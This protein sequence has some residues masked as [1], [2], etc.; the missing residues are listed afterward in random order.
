[1]RSHANRLSE[2]GE[3]DGYTVL[4]GTNTNDIACYYVPQKIV[5]FKKYQTKNLVQASLIHSTH[6]DFMSSSQYIYI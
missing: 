3:P 5:M 1:M 2:K 6:M 4:L